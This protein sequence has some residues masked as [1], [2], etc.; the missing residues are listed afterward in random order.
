MI[1]IK[2]RRGLH[3]F[4]PFCGRGLVEFLYRTDFD[5]NKDSSHNHMPIAFECA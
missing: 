4:N 2:H 1:V 5:E 3:F